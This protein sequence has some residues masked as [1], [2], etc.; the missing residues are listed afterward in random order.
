MGPGLEIPHVYIFTAFS[1]TND[2]AWLVKQQGRPVVESLAYSQWHGL[3][4]MG[5]G[6]PSEGGSQAGRR[7][8]NR[9]G[10]E[11]TYGIIAQEAWRAGEGHQRPNPQRSLMQSLQ[12]HGLRARMDSV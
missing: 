9:A 3:R 7:Y 2:V 8:R 5:K 10:A 1:L 11:V 4:V 12:L 6:R